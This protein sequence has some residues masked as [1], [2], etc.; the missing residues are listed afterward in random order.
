[1]H[2]LKFPR[3]SAWD[4]AYAIDT[5]VTAEAAS[6]PGR[7]TNLARARGEAVYASRDKQ[8]RVGQY[9]SIQRADLVSLSGSNPGSPAFPGGANK[10]HHVLKLQWGT[11]V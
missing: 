7:A 5:A 11:C 2:R 8:R 3:V 10:R 6:D 1:M 9:W 4:I